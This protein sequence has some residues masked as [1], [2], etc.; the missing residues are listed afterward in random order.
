MIICKVKVNETKEAIICFRIGHF[1]ILR[2]IEQDICE[3]LKLS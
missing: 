2:E 1:L 3:G